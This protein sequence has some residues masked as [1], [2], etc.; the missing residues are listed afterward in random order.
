VT[1]R[2]TAA[3]ASVYDTRPDCPARRH[4]D[5]SAYSFWHCRCPDA[6][7][8]WRLYK[9]RLREGRQPSAYVDAT[10]TARRLRALVAGGY[11]FADLGRALGW[12]RRRVANVAQ[13]LDPKVMVRTA[14][15]VADVYDRLSTTPGTSTYA[16]IVARRYGWHPSL[17]WDDDTIDDPTATPNLGAPVDELPDEEAVRRALAGK[18]SFAQLQPADRVEAYRRLVVAGAGP[19]TISRR[20]GISTATLRALAAAADAD[21]ERAA[22]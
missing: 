15:A 22:A 16:R 17:A 3:G 6:R 18:A 20:L 2:T 4:G 12:G 21:H 11:N 14:N 7:E 1:H 13:M 10:G 5:R 8:D 9:K 19:G